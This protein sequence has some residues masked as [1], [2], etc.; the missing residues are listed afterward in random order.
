VTSVV[1]GLLG[2]HHGDVVDQDGELVVVEVL[3]Q[4]VVEV[5]ELLQAVIIVEE[6]VYR[7]VFVVEQVLNRCA[8]LA[9]VVGPEVAA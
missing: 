9:A 8:T 1:S 4:L 2:R 3:D 5:L 7:A 6:L